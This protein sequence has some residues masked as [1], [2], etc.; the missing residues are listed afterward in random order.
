MIEPTGVAAL[1]VGDCLADLL[2]R[3][4]VLK[5]SSH[6]RNAGSLDKR[7][8]CLDSTEYFWSLLHDTLS[9]VNI[10][11]VPSAEHDWAELF[12]GR[13]IFCDPRPQKHTACPELYCVDNFTQ[14]DNSRVSDCAVLPFT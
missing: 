13:L 6:D 1:D 7:T 10:Q 9:S 12:I 2:L 14:N 11:N 8:D 4:F 5:C 3:C